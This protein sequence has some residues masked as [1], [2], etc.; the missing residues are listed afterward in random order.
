MSNYPC[1]LCHSQMMVMGYC[2]K[3]WQEIKET[4]TP[5]EMKKSTPSV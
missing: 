2:N 3:H 4:W 5:A 1:K